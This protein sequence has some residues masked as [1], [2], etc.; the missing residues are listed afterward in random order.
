LD[1]CS[2]QIQDE[3]V[4]FAFNYFFIPQEE[5]HPSYAHSDHVLSAVLAH[6]AIVAYTLT[7][8]LLLLVRH[9]SSIWK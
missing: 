5:L 2:C 9:V 4:I 6:V 7:A 3:A 1:A 8:A